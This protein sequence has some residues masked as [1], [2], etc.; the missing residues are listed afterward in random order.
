MMR[1]LVPG[2][3]VGVLL[4]ATG[5]VA[6]PPAVQSS[7]RST[8]PF[9]ESGIHDAVSA[10]GHLVNPTKTSGTANG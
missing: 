4:G 2:L 5:V 3:V 9:V 6:G 10:V 7:L 1:G 8:V